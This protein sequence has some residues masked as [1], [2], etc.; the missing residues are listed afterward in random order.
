MTA[1]FEFQELWWY[2]YWSQRF[3]KMCWMGKGC[4]PLKGA[5]AE[6][7]L[8][9]DVVSFTEILFFF[10]K[11]L[12][13]F[14]VY[15]EQWSAQ[16]RNGVGP[17]QKHQFPTLPTKRSFLMNKQFSFCYT[18]WSIF[19]ALKWLFLIVLSSFLLGREDLQT[20]LVLPVGRSHSKPL[21]L[22]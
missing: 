13:Q 2:Y 7:H 1:K 19:R 11:F 4:M 18:S 6:S 10:L 14:N 21:T 16:W 8:L 3:V 17:T 12:L 20:S 5:T 22:T 15:K 9:K